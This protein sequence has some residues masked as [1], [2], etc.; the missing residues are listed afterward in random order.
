MAT[1]TGTAA[2]ES[3][4]GGIAD[5][6]ISGLDGNDTLTGD[7]GGDE[8][9]G[10]AGDDRLIG[11]Y[12]DDLQ[13]GGKGADR[14]IYNGRGF[15][16][17]TIWDFGAGDKVDLSALGVADMATLDPYLN[18]EAG[19]AVLRLFSFG[20]WETI[21]FQGLTK[22]DLSATSF[23]F[24]TST[25]GLNTT[26]TVSEDVLFGGKGND[27]LTG[28]RGGDELN[29]GAGD[30]RLIGGYGDDLQRGGKGADRFIFDSSVFN[31]AD[32]VADFS[33][34]QGDIIDLSLIDANSTITNDQA[35]TIVSGS[36]TAAG[37]MKITNNHDGTFTIDL[38]TDSNSDIDAI[39][40]VNSST[41]LIATDFS[42]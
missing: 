28:D 37:Q 36:F 40:T 26:G 1:L 33:H 25:S 10:G 6:K 20:A 13:R 22:S 27:T 17:D 35:F 39:I 29:G 31:G 5:D 7:R 41:S 32:M 12:G 38:N 9:N 34:S 42:L 21:T 15:G 14:F 2:S 11:G 3:L 4:T 30:D 16:E 24:N 19:V 18:D 8:L 23:L